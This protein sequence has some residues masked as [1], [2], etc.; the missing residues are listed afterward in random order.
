ME[1]R[2]AT[3]EDL[4]YIV[5]VYNSTI[6]GRMSTAD[7][8]P[9]TVS[10]KKSWFEQHDQLHPIWII[11]EHHQ[12]VGWASLSKFHERPAYVHTAEAGIYLQ[13]QFRGKGIGKKATKLLMEQA[14]QLGFKSL[15]ALVFAHNTASRQILSHTGFSEWGHLP[16]VAVMDEQF[17]DLCILGIHL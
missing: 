7:I 14:K 17:Y 6:P 9:V 12:P 15:V 13:E 2:I 10:A 5:E 3:I 8:E 1:F 16:A 11:E 4:P